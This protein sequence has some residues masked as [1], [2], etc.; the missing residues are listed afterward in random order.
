MVFH[1]RSSD[2]HEATL[3]DCVAVV[4]AYDAWEN[5]GLG[6]GYTLLRST[7]SYFVRA[8]A[9]GIGPSPRASFISRPSPNSGQIP[10]FLSPMVPSGRAPIIRW[11]TAER[12]LSTGRTYAVGVSEGVTDFG[13][14]QEVLSGLGTSA[15]DLAFSQLRVILL[16]QAGYVQCHYTDSPRGGLGPGGHLLD[17]TGQGCYQLTGSQRRRTR[18]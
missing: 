3:A 1:C 12:G 9:F 14:D 6:I 17:I 2:G 16:N 7:D 8:G 5:D 11:A 18:H 10:S 13:D 4:A 15:L